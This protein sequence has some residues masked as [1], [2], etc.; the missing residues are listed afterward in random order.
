MKRPVATALRRRVGKEFP[1]PCEGKNGT[2]NGDLAPLLQK[3]GGRPTASI[4][5]DMMAWRESIPSPAL[6]DRHL[7]M[8]SNAGKHACFRDGLRCGGR[9]TRKWIV[10]EIVAG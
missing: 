2:G 10:G 3:R 9:I 6:M 8:L 5:L 1:A 7:S 4:D